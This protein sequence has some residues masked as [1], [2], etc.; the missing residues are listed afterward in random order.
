[1]HEGTSITIEYISCS[2]NIY[3]ISL[4]TQFSNLIYL[5]FDHN[6]DKT[7]INSTKADR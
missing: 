6:T 3:N 7:D 4:V 5:T 1:M 2:Y